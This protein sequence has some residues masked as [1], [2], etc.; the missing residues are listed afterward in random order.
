MENRTRKEG[1]LRDFVRKLRA[2]EPPVAAVE[3]ILRSCAAG[4]SGK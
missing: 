4:A 1:S 2:L 3:G